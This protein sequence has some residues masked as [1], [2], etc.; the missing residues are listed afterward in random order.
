MIISASRRTDIPAYYSEW[1]YRRIEEGYCTVPNPFNAEQIQ[2]VDLHPDAVSAIVFWTR[3]PSP[4]ANRISILDQL[5]Y[6]YYFQFTINNYPKLYEPY[7][8]TINTALKSFKH[9]S[10][11]LGKGKVIWRYDPIFFTDDLTLEF[12]K[13]NFIYICREL[14]GYTKRLVISIIDDYAKTLRRLG[15]LKTNYKENQLNKPQLLELLSFIVKNASENGIEVES[16]AEEKDFSNIGIRHGKCID[17]KL[18]YEEFGIDLIYKKDKNQRMPC[19]CMVSKDIGMNNTC[20]MGC[21]YCYATNSHN[22]AI[23]NK[24]RHDPSFSSLVIHKVS[25]DLNKKI[26]TLKSVRE[27]KQQQ[28]VLF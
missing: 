16:C 2:V 26:N 12:H 11:R 27:F 15:K 10:E 18:L 28:I 6:K 24:K 25:N 7:N 20:L 19:G 1:F 21:E 8:P 13:S 22:L 23:K 4:L 5:G 9:F 17:D 14:S 3:N